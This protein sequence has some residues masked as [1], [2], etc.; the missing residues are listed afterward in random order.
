MEQNKAM[1]QTMIALKGSDHAVNWPHEVAARFG[2]PI[3]HVASAIN[4]IVGCELEPYQFHASKEN[5]QPLPEVANLT[6]L[7]AAQ[8]VMVVCFAAEA[9]TA[10][11]SL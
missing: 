4:N 8:V 9:R 10:L 2:L 6:E 1:T 7:Q 3:R 5:G 11:G